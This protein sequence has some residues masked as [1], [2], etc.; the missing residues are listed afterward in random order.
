MHMIFLSA[1]L[2]IFSSAAT[3]LAL[4][5]A[6]V[7]QKLIQLTRRFMLGR[8]L[9]WAIATRVIFALLLWLCAPI[10]T[11]PNVFRALALI[12][13]LAIIMLPVIGTARILELLDDLMELPEVILRGA[14][15]LA[16]A[17]FLFVFWST[18]V[19]ML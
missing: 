3:A 2:M 18:S 7:P 6:L 9:W 15:L 16:I 14:F 12:T 1:S 11:M 10:A 13:L 5:G 4:Y 19:W 8:G 17:L